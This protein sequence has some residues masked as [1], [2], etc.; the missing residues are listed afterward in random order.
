M[1]ILQVLPRYAPAWSYGGGVRMF[2]YLACELTRLGHEVRVVTS[3]SVNANTRTPDLRE[4]LEGGIKVTRYRNRFNR[5]SAQAGALF[6]RPRG[7]RL[8]V[9]SEAEWADVIH[10]GES[11]GIH[12]VW[13]A[14]A[15]GATGVPLV[16]SAYG[17]LPTASG[18][19][20]VYRKVYDIAFTKSVIANVE[21][22]IAQTDHESSVYVGHGAPPDRIRLI[23]LCVDTE[24]FATPPERGRF[25]RQL[26]LAQDDLL[27]VCVARLSPVK[28]MDLLIDA[29]ARLPA[30]VHGPY[31][32]L[33]GWNHGAEPALRAQVK[34][35][36]LDGRVL[37]PG[38]LLGEDRLL[39]YIDADVFALTPAVYEETSLAAL[40]AAALGIPT[41]LT[42]ECEIPLMNEAGA[43]VVAERSGAGVAAALSRLLADG[44]TRVAMGSR[45]K[46][47]VFER[48]GVNSIARQHEAV[49]E[50]VVRTSVARE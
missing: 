5:L 38:A 31:L 49:F 46:D 18:V 35:L 30:Q 7:M 12:N 15:A 22:F 37:F 21:R 11:R 50:E 3:D 34:R 17:G 47:L 2:W 48:F 45:A 28:G 32:A 6:Y 1:R 10:M 25:R 20:G 33:V 4:T 9:R 43:G 14:E 13:A 36:K 23:P 29:F 40:E 8:G 24:A 19:R 44:A 39:A 27:V 42:A 41:V 26:G 16:W